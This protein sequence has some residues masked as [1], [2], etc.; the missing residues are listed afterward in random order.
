MSVSLCRRGMGF[1]T[2]HRFDSDHQYRHLY[3]AHPPRNPPLVVLLPAII[4]DGPVGCRRRQ[5]L[6][7]GRPGA[8]P[9]GVRSMSSRWMIIAAQHGR[10]RCQRGFKLGHLIFCRRPGPDPASY[11][12]PR[13]AA[14]QSRR[15]TA[16]ECRKPNPLAQS[17]PNEHHLAYR[18]PCEQL[19]HCCCCHARSV[20]RQ[21]RGMFAIDLDPANHDNASLSLAHVLDILRL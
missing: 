20:S 8:R 12:A 11:S 19:C 6:V 3:R 9:E 15:I 16:A 1:L 21:L 10:E 7:Q 18:Q 4:I 13:Q 17:A 14:R 2:A 5:G